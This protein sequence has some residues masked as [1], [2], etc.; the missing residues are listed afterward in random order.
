ME[1]LLK[2]LTEIPGP[3]GQEEAIKKVIAQEIK[4]SCDQLWEDP[5]GNLIARIGPESGYRI[6]ILAH[7]DEVGLIVT[8]IS[9]RGLIGFEMIGTIDVRLLP[10]REVDIMGKDGR[11]FRGVIGNL[12]RHLQTAEDL[13]APVSIKQLFIDT[14]SRSREDLQKEGVD[15]G[16]GV[17]FATPFH[18][19]PNGTVL[20]KALD[21]RISCAVLIK[22]L[23]GLHGQ[24]KKVGVY[25]MFTVQEEI[26]AKGAGVVAFDLRPSL[27]ITL[28]NVPTKNP[29]QISA[30]EV[31]L[32]RGPVIRI[33]DWHPA[34]KLGMFTHPSI[35]K[36]LLEV[37]Q[38]EGIPHQKD[39]LTSTYLDS[40]TAHLT[41]GGIPGGSICFPRRYSHSPVEMS[42]LSDMENGLKLLVSFVKTL[43]ENPIQF[44]RTY[45]IE[46]QGGV[47]N[48]TK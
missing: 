18:R 24:L 10:G 5:L 46:K 21:N 6:G 39:V 32:G 40:S 41:A 44:G 4:Q 13:A 35:K 43:E 28:D 27:A 31:D 38:K 22:T 34:T 19:W 1:E 9:D 7:M 2:K 23:E 29:D 26:G 30:G 36:R 48:D 25:G 45:G 8:R 42:N 16:S 33:F 14:G 12:S 17:V 11:L 3:S 37:A 15:I 20:A 47:K